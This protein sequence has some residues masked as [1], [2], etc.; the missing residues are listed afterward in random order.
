MSPYPCLSDLA[1]GVDYVDAVE[2]RGRRAVRDRADLARLAL[3]VEEGAAH[4]P[5]AL[6]A[7]GGAGI[8]EVL[9]VRLVGHVFQHLADLA[10]LD[11]EVKLAA[12]LEVVALLVDR[13]GTAPEDVDAALDVL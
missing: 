1:A 2:A 8:P 6:V 12:E 4:A 7:Q 5:V 11:L 13:V 10:V 9:G 3:A